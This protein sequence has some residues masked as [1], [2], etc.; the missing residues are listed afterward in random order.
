MELYTVS[1]LADRLHISLSSAYRLLD[2]RRIQY[3]ILGKK[4]YRVSEEAIQ[5]YL[6]QQTVAAESA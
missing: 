6:E 1:E 3:L 5:A 2:E 4:S